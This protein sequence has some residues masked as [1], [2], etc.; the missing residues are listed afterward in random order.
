MNELMTEKSIFLEALD[1]P[2]ATERAG[3]SKSA[4]GEWGL[5]SW[6]NS[7]SLFDERWP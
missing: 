2:S 4:K 3:L 1:K 6:P 5:S 7:K